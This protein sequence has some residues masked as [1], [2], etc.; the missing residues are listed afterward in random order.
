A[1]L[2]QRL[3]NEHASS[4]L[5]AQ[6]RC[7]VE[8]TITLAWR[9]HD[10]EA[11]LELVE[12]Q[13]S[14]ALAAALREAQLPEVGQDVALAAAGAA[15]L[16]AEADT[17]ADGVSAQALQDHLERR[18]RNRRLLPLAHADI[19]SPLDLPALR[20]AFQQAFP[21]GWTLLS[22]LPCGAQ[23][24]IVLMDHEGLSLVA[25]PLDERLRWLLERATSP[26]YHW[27]TYMADA[28]TP[29]PARWA[30]LDELGARLL[31]AQALARLQPGHRLLIIAGG[32]L[33]GLPWA[34]LRAGGRWLVE[35]ATP[36][37]L[38]GLLIWQK[39][40]GHRPQG[41]AAL[42]IG[43]SAFGARAPEL[44]G[45]RATLELVEQRWPGRVARLEDGQARVGALRD[46]AARGEL[47][48][49]ALLHVATHGQLVATSGLLAHLKL[50]DDDLRYDEIARLNL[51]GPLV[52]LAACEGAA[53]E[54][55][56]GEE[57]LSLSRAFL[58][59]GARDV[60]ASEWQL[61]D[62]AAPLFLALLYDGLAAGLD[63][64]SA[65]AGAQRA[66]LRRP[67]EA[68]ELGRLAGA[69][70]I[71]ASMS[72]LGAGTAPEE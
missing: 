24:L 4:G 45:V 14:L 5:F 13:R 10:A 38:P 33:N 36:Q 65:L 27:L 49:Y 16:S 53:G 42:L 64:P 37:L 67:A 28:M 29:G 48:S 21:A 56:P 63:A 31:P 47:R 51:A 35:Q 6:A 69:P 62:K 59:A 41:S 22:Y 7:L 8:E 66:W 34:A 50:A 19:L 68:S 9:Q 55:L 25:T 12:L 54:V 57:I 11:A 26:Q 17:V 32:P 3:A 52:V 71:W 1:R 40:L 46:L 44:Q 23:V 60:I 2:R 72:A 20:A 70:L 30:V 18:L 15:P 61:Y 43:V 39:L 58:A